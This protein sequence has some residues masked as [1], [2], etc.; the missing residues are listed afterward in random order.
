MFSK[1]KHMSQ[2]WTVERVFAS[3]SEATE[4]KTVVQQSSRGATL[5]VKIIDRVALIL[6]VFAKRARTREGQLQVE[7]A[8]L[9]YMLPRLTGKGVIMS[10]TG[11]GVAGQHNKVPFA[12]E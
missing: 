5:Q 11:G 10:R 3:Y 1:E 6:D 7:L 4:F 8:Q 12:A 9:S 2:P